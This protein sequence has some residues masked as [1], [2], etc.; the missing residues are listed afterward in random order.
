M[1][2]RPPGNSTDHP[3]Q[4]S[5]GNAAPRRGGPAAMVRWGPYVLALSV[6]LAAVG[7]RLAMGFRPGDAPM[8]ILFLVAPMVCAYLG[9]LGPGLAATLVSAVV[10]NIF[11]LP[12]LGKFSLL[13]GLLS[14][15]W[16]M[17]ILVGALVSVL[18]ETLR[19]AGQRFQA[20]LE[21][22]LDAIV[23]IDQAGRI[24]EFNRAAER[25][26]GHAAGAVL[27]QEMAEVIVPPAYRA[28]HRAD[29]A[30]LVA[31]DEARRL[32]RRLE[33]T[34]L[35]ADGSEFPVEISIQRVGA[36]TPARFTAFIR[37]IAG[38]RRAEDALRQS[39]ERYRDLVEHSHDLL[40]THD[41]AGNLLSAN[42]AAV[43][44]TGYAHAQLLQMN[45][46]DLLAPDTRRGFTAY[47][48]K[49]HRHGH[50]EGVMRIRT[51]AG[52]ERWWK[53]SNSLRRDGVATPVVRGIAQDVTERRLWEAT[54]R[55]S[56]E[57][58]RAIF[59]QAPLG[60]AEG[61]I[62]SEKFVRFN[63]RYADIVGYPRAELETMSFRDFTHPEDLDQDL[64]LYGRLA[65]GEVRSFA[66]EKRYVRRDGATVW[67]NLSVA[68]MQRPGGAPQNCM[69][70]IE[71]ITERKLLEA[72]FRQ[73]QKMEAIGQLSGGVAHDFNN[74]ITVIKGRATLLLQD[75]GVAP[76]HADSVREIAEAAERA[77]G[78]T[79]QLLAFSRRQVMHLRDLDLNATVQHMATMLRRLLG[80]DVRVELAFAPAPL[81]THA[82]LGMVEQ[83]LL[84][85][86]VNARD[87]MPRGGELWIST[88]AAEVDE[89]QARRWPQGRAGRFA[90]LTVRDTGE[91]I[92]PEILPRIFE[93]FF[94]TKEPGAGTGLGLA[95][96]YGIVQQ[97]HGGLEVESTV[98]RGTTFRIY[99]P[100]CAAPAPAAAAV[101]PATPSSAG[102]E[103]I[104][105]VED[106]PAVRDIARLV[107]N[108]WA[109]A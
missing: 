95:T 19:Q 20:I 56:A 89:A 75:A 6:P 54:L 26:F 1:A 25:M 12:P 43:R 105:L 109:T 59:E 104:L 45:L 28:A 81:W 79:R 73:A 4:P 47:L 77:A 31:P 97:H 86:A 41:L 32:G 102:S 64:A 7:F 21:S 107:C 48:A 3:P 36:A 82:D 108:I 23:V 67:V 38:R 103:T 72:Q 93:P 44:L 70:M 29:L 2:E 33:M 61:E 69:A 80:E 13:A 65:A 10:T 11:L 85:L 96:V 94:T 84:N 92:A 62:C 68:A 5:E 57:R 49:I 78:L 39:E 60:I 76:D 58:F 91:G 83:V 99:L 71:D 90:L 66:L 63:Q 106:E 22:S 101:A 42:A 52:A 15:Q 9:G 53:Y 50:A 27:G 88:A 55:E 14:P 18:S 30:R 87:A 100:G 34:A 24:E 98:G 8:M 51:A 40:C 16:L 35:R 37:D 74:L 17:L 46:R